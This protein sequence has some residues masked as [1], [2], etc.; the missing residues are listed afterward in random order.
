MYPAR[1]RS[2]LYE[3]M[4]RTIIYKALFVRTSALFSLSLLSIAQ[5]SPPRPPL[6][7][8]PTFLLYIYRYCDIYVCTMYKYA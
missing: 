4:H 1:R 7:V 8:V 6:A 3:G 5:L 2:M